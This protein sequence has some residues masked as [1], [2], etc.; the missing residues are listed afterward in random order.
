MTRSR[1]TIEDRMKVCRHR[2]GLSRDI[3]EA[4]VRYDEVSRRA[5]LGDLGCFCRLPCM[6][7]EPGTEDNGQIV[8]PCEQYESTPREDIE[9][10]ERDME[11]AIELM[12]K[13][14]SSCC[15]ATIDES[16]V[17]REGEH[18]GHGPRYCSECGKVAYMV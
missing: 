11:R 6:G 2:G 4:N 1:R 9:Q 13:G 12:K 3:C 14:L 15:E 10:A 16:H 8:Q 17:I 5:E 18:K 7:K